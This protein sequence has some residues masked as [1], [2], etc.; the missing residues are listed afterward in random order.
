MAEKL[1]QTYANH[2][3]MHPPFHFFLM[4]AT[5]LLLILTIVNVVRHSGAL[6]AWILL[7]I[8]VMAPVAVLLI[9]INPLRVQDRLIRLEEQQRFL[10]LLP[11]QLKSRLGDLTEAQIVALRFASDAELPGLVEKTLSSKMAGKDIKKAIVT[12]RADT[13]RV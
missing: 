6:E 12:W 3:R 7:L 9:R 11:P 10:A 2:T 8:G 13:F 4:P 5:L 1:P